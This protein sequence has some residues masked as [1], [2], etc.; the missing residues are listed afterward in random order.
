MLEQLPQ[1]RMV[2]NPLQLVQPLLRRL[3]EQPG[4][5]VGGRLST[6]PGG[7]DE[8]GLHLAVADRD[9]GRDDQSRRGRHDERQPAP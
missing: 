1:G 3:H 5:L 9:D 4:E 6:D 7:L 8:V 2:R